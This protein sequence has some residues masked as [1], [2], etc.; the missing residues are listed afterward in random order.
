[1]ICWLKKFI[2]VLISLHQWN[3]P[4]SP[5]TSLLNKIGNFI[6]YLQ[7]DFAKGNANPFKICS[8]LISGI[9]NPGFI[10]VSMTTHQSLCITTP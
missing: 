5:F 9:R 4:Q 2:P 1:M 3:T 8:Y 6:N 7:G 10:H